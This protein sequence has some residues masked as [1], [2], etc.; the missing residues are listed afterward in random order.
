MA[1]A[2]KETTT[3]TSA[4]A[5]DTPKTEIVIKMTRLNPVFEVTNPET[6][7]KYRFTQAA[8][9]VLVRDEKDVNFLLRMHGMEIATPQ[10]VAEYYDK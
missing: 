2:K 9:Y 3:K 10:Q 5:D 6:D 8:P 7:N 1:T 4:K